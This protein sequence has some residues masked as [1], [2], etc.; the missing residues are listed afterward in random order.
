MGGLEKNKQNSHNL[1][2][3]SKRLRNSPQT[4]NLEKKP[5]LNNS[6]SLPDLPDSFDSFHSFSTSEVVANS[7]MF[8]SQSIDQALATTPDI[9]SLICVELYE[10]N[11]EELK[12]P[13]LNY[14]D[15]LILFRHV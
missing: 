15:A 9:V 13:S 8:G 6:S 11:G 10:L 5:N 1:A 12:S 2:M 3:Y 7:T 4:E 14:Y